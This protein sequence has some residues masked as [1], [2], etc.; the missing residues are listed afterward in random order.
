MYLQICHF[1]MSP[2]ILTIYPTSLYQIDCPLEERHSSYLYSANYSMKYTFEYIL[3]TLEQDIRIS[4]SMNVEITIECYSEEKLK[5]T[6]VTDD[7]IEWNNEKNRKDFKND[8][9]SQLI[10]EMIYS[11]SEKILDEYNKKGEY[12]INKVK[13]IIATREGDINKKKI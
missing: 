5:S 13:R 10:K 9:L 12:N 4:N 7:F 6:L 8:W 3:C 11:E 1:F 2:P